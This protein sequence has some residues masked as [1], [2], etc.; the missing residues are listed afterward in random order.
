MLAPELDQFHRLADRQRRAGAGRGHR[1][2]HAADA[3]GMREAG[4]ERTAH[5]ARHE[6]RRQPADTLGAI[7]VEAG[8]VFVQ[9]R[10][11]ADH[12]AAVT[13]GQFGG[14]EPGVVDRLAHR[15]PRIQRR[16]RQEASQLARWLG[17]GADVDRSA[18]A[19]VQAAA[20][21]A[22][23]RLQAA[24]VLAQR[25]EKRVAAVAQA[26]DHAGAGDH[27]PRQPARIEQVGRHQ[28]QARKISEVL[29]PP[30]AKLLFITQSVSSDGRHR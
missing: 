21:K 7:S 25:R 6:K 10:A 12:Q 27:H 3:E 20:G 19:R 23:H 2:G 5:A 28:S 17:Q 26:A 30:K 24:A 15:M 1:L 29:M 16:L 8:L 11:A 22:V 18:D 13:R 4:G 14:G 9:R